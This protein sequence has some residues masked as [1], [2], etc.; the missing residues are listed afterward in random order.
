MSPF[1]AMHMEHPAP[2]HSKPAASKILSSPRR[3]A[4]LRTATEPGTTRARTP[5][6]TFFPLTTFATSSKSE[7]RALV[8]DPIKTV[9][10]ERS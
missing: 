5:F 10:T 9:S 7:M 6:F 4:S 2:R 8:H 3:S 1:I